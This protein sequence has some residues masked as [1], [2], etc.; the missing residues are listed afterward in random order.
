MS[1]S[2]SRFRVDRWSGG[3]AAAVG[4][5]VAGVLQGSAVL[6]VAATVP[7]AYVVY[8]ALD[9]VRLSAGDVA[10]ERRIDRTAAF[11][12]DEVEVAVAVTNEGDRP[13]VDLRVADVV[14]EGV[15]VVEGSPRGAMALR[16]GETGTVRYAVV[17]RRGDHEFGPVRV[18]GRSTSGTD[19]VTVEVAPEEGR[20]SCRP[21]LETIPLARQTRPF[22]G[23]VG[24][25]D[26]GS[27][28]EFHSTRD[29][30]RG[31]PVSRV[32]WRRFAK[33]GDLTTVDYR[34]HR[35]TRVVVAVDA[36][37]PCHVAGA[38]GGP[39]GAAMCAYGARR[40][41][42]TLRAA[43][44][45]VGATVL[46][47]PDRLGTGGPAWVDPGTDEETQIRALELFDAA[48]EPPD[49]TRR[50][51]RA[52]DTAGATG[53]PGAGDAPAGGRRAPATATTDGGRGGRP[54]EAGDERDRKGR[55]PGGQTARSP[56]THGSGGRR[57]G[58]PEDRRGSGRRN[59][60]GRG[61]R[62]RDHTRRG[63]IGAAERLPE[64]LSA[65]AQ[66][67]LFTPALDDVP[68]EVV[69]TVTAHGHRVTVVSPDVTGPDTTGGRIE[70]V[71]RRLRLDDLRE[72][73]ATVVDWDRDRPLALTLDAVLEGLG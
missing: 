34:E 13:L 40:S 53:R 2:E 16:P 9:R 17:A 38:P 35:T 22:A 71:E 30:R 63:G 73:G 19:V 23:G 68:E 21:D 29:Y 64:R 56:T 59:R 15:A 7:V 72:A 54:S 61:A 39:T 36:R 32:D 57:R 6:F 3:L 45:G 67:L 50:D 66:L 52:A 65:N 4:L 51:R 18:R 60:R 31:D 69:R 62:G 33:T 58:P 25:D 37:E 41:F 26:A 44:H 27:G 42:E 24:T 1:G 12:G 8:G 43:G 14:P 70:S 47:I 49:R 5:S 10:V 46:G 48:A 11:P 28:V 55:T 20:I